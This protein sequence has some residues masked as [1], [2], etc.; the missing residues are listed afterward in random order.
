M[1]YFA[2][3]EYEWEKMS[4][5]KPGLSLIKSA[6]CYSLI[7][8]PFYYYIFKI[9]IECYKIDLNPLSLFII[10]EF[11]TVMIK[12]L[13]CVSFIEKDSWYNLDQKNISLLFFC[14]VALSQYGFKKLPNLN[15]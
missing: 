2:Y 4:K 12:I 13:L 11:L 10:S 15:Y 14:I 1:N 8:I 7:Y 6:F 3:M 5:L 9:I